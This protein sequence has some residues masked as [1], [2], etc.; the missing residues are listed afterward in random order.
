MQ[1]AIRPGSQAKSSTA[2]AC[3][4]GALGAEGVGQSGC[5]SFNDSEAP[6]DPIEACLMPG[7]RRVDV[8]N[9]LLHR[10]H[11]PAHRLHFCLQLIN[12]MLDRAETILNLV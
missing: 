3:R 5:D 9:A 1:H 4:A 2:R 6:L 10:H 7:E 11:V 8:V 12:F